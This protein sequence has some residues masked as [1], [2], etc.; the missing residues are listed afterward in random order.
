VTAAVQLSAVIQPAI[1]VSYFGSDFAKQARH[2]RL[3]NDIEGANLATACYKVKKK[4]KWG[5][6]KYETMP[7]A[8]EHSEKRLHDFLEDLGVEYKVIWVYTELEPC[9]ADYHN[10]AQRLEDWWPTAEVY[11]SVDYPSLDDVSSE[12][13]DDDGEKK[14]NKA[15][16]RRSRGPATLKRFKTFS[17]K[18]DSDEDESPSPADFPKLRRIHSPLHYSSGVK[19]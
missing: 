14:R 18:W 5:G 7:S 4:G 12:S 6:L 11:Y 9:G 16:R 10:C 1:Q 19:L 2:Y 13:S 15:K 3:K 8:G 17:K